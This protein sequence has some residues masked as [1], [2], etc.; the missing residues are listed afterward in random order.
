MSSL[1]SSTAKNRAH[2]RDTSRTFVAFPSFSNA[3]LTRPSVALKSLK[4][5][6]WSA[7]SQS[8]RRIRNK[9]QSRYT[10]VVYSKK[11]FDST[12]RVSLF[13]FS[14]TLKRHRYTSATNTTR[15]T[16]Y[17]NRRFNSVLTAS[18][19]QRRFKKQTAFTNTA[20][21]ASSEFL[22]FIMLLVCAKKSRM[23]SAVVSRLKN[24]WR[25][26]HLS[27]ACNN[28]ASTH[29]KTRGAMSVIYDGA[30]TR[31]DVFR[32]VSV[33]FL[34]LKWRSC[35]RSVREHLQPRQHS[36]KRKSCRHFIATEALKNA[37]RCHLLVRD[38]QK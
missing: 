2:F 11:R 29:T 8:W 12:K 9:H 37:W 23:F 26:C 4:S 3:R 34:P 16:E 14:D 32:C 38:Y 22:H 13:R 21:C 5:L 31:I 17:R 6:T 15:I 35:C 1:V 28:L 25:Y 27:S 18:R 19:T 20:H 30:R 36:A 7:L 33:S 24:G 10:T